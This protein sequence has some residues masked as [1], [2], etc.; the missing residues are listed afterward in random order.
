M[1]VFGLRNNVE[2]SKYHV[3]FNESSVILGEILMCQRLSSN[4]S[5]LGFKKE[6]DKLKEVLWSPKTPEVGPSM[7][8]DE[9]DAPAHANKEFE[10]SKVPY[11]AT[12]SSRPF[13]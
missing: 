5:S 8:K 12:H 11:E 13:I 2:K 6:E 3:N 4:K 1:E 10:N 7:T 9:S